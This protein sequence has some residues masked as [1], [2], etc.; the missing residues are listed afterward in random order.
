MGEKD[1]FKKSFMNFLNI[2]DKNFIEIIKN[3]SKM[4]KI[5][6]FEH[7]LFLIKLRD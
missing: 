5:K 3:H 4:K 2:S 7:Y 6:F 1:F